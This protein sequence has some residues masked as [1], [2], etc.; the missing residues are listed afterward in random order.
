MSPAKSERIKLTASLLNS[1]SSGTILA[2]LV[3]PYV[4]IGMG[5]LSTQTDLFNLFSLSVFGVAVG[6]VLHL[7]ARRTLGKLE[8]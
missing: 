7:G 4:G 8:E 5:T 2:A 3:A 6:A 1:L